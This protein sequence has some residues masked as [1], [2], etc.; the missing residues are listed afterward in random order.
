MNK[1]KKL[2]DTATLWLTLEQWDQI[3]SHSASWLYRCHKL[4]NSIH[5]YS[6][7]LFGR[8][9]GKISPILEFIFKY[10]DKIVK[11]IERVFK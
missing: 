1:V 11:R 8:H 9:Y 5:W 4:Q 6:S 10:S 3:T 2:E 7:K